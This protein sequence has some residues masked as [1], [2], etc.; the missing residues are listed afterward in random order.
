[1]RH[2]GHVCNPELVISHF[3][4]KLLTTPTPSS[5]EAAGDH[6]CQQKLLSKGDVPG[7]DI[8]AHSAHNGQSRKSVFSICALEPS[9]YC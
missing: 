7:I 9:L 2:V 3:E 8:P 5:E 4:L 1:M 6:H